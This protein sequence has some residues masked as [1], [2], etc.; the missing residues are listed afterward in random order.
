MIIGTH[1]LLGLE[2]KNLAFVVIDEE[3]KFGVKQKEKLKDLAI[4]LHLLSMSATPIPRSLNLALSEVKSFS[5]ILTPPDLRL[6]V[7]TFVKS[8]D[9]KIVKEAIVKELR[10]G[11]QILYI[12]NSIAGIE[13]KKRELLNLISTLRICTL[14]S[15]IPPLQ[16]EDEM[17][18]F[19]AG[20][21]DLMLS[22]SIIESGIH[23][24]KANTIIVD[25][26]D[27]FGMAD[28]HQLRG[29]VGRGDKEGWCWFLV[30]DRELLS[31]NAKKRLLALESNSSLGSGAVLAFHDLE[32]RGGGNIIGEAQS[33]HINQIGY[34]LYLKMLEDSIRQLQ[35]KNSVL[36]T[37]VDIKLSVNAYLNDELI[38]EDRLR[39]ELYR[40]LSFVQ[41]VQK[42]YDIELEIADRFG[43]LDIITRQFIDVTIIK[44][45]A[46]EKGILKISNFN[47]NILIEYSDKKETL[48]ASSRDDDDI[49]NCVK[50]FF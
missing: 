35:G 10:R 44:V 39:L 24:P 20:D 34:S 7:K 15:K 43:K 8:F 12:F 19:E 23:M 22:T 31:E 40:R 45:L 28:L 16:M 2:F 29:R 38:Q 21:Y 42:V 11:G 5:E 30:Q 25:E 1:A 26:A 33:G 50:N 14:H 46:R 27:N 49:I 13:E 6:G 32:I 3:H 47:E 9:E 37:P 17:I 36:D 41:N 48:K 18:K 4:N